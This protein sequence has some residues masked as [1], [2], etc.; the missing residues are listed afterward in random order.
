MSAGASTSTGA[1]RG[2]SQGYAM[3]EMATLQM[4]YLTESETN[5]STFEGVKWIIAKSELLIVDIVDRGVP[6]RGVI[7]RFAVSSKLF[8][9]VDR[10]TAEL[11]VF[12]KSASGLVEGRKTYFIVDP[13][14]TCLPVL[15]GASDVA[16]LQAAWSLLRK[17]VELGDRYFS[18]YR[19]EYEQGKAMLSP[20]S[21][22]PDLYDP[23]KAES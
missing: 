4:E 23:L 8:A 11:Q 10:I 20:T 17:R 14:D 5:L 6:S 7:A 22:V 3:S 16:Q 15:Q 1:V 13:E 19:D 2:M 21:T 9:R 18:K 12:L